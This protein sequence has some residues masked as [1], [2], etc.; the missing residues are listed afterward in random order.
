MKVNLLVYK[1]EVLDVI[2]MDLI[3][4]GMGVVKVDNYLIFI[5]NVLLEEKIMVKVMKMMKNFVFGDVEKIN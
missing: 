5:E 1:G 3:Y 4:Q 2:I